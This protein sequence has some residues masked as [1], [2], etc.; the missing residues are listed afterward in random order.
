MKGN[1]AIEISRRAVLAGLFASAGQAAVAGAPLASPLP[2]ARAKGP[3]PA[4][5]PSVAEILARADLGGKISFV[6]ADAAS[7]RILESM[8]PLLGQPPASVTKAITA[9]YALDVL[10]P[11]HAFST[12]LIGT[13]TLKNGRL[14]GDLY[15]VGG[16]DPTLD[17]TALAEMA[18]ALKAAGVT[19]VAGQFFVSSGSLPHIPRIDPSQPDHLGYNP[20]V[21]GLNLNYNRV[22]FEWK[23]SGASYK[24]T[25]DA[26]TEK[27][28]PNITMARMEIVNRQAP[29]Y[30]YANGGGTE[31]WTVASSALGNSG[32]R[33]LPVRQPELYAGE[34]FHGFAR[35]M[36]IR[37]KRA[38]FSEDRINGRVLVDRKSPPLSRIM[39]GMLAYSNNLTAEVCG[40]SASIASGQTVGE[41]PQSGQAMADWMKTRLGARNPRFVD[42]SGLGENTRVSSSDMVRALVHVG[43]DSSLASILKPLVIRNQEGKV[44]LRNRA[45]MVAKTGTL[46]F[47]SGLS[48]F[49]HTDKRD[50]LVFAIFSADLPRRNSLSVAERERP[51][52]AKS[53]TKR[54]R[55][56]QWGLINRWID[57]HG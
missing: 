23:R 47:V 36:G 24:I 22:H 53:W 9:Q 33:W 41:L 15:L 21:S 35:S 31:R 54:A 43:P 3:L 28:R 4:P 38:V 17:S 6:V 11:A 45:Q 2:I 40:L 27:Y 25:M 51:V 7:G 49:I 32:S 56:M 12:R 30:T 13:G 34:V 46:N 14:S 50:A 18:A 8:N 48:G 20:A 29:V 55:A 26:R 5:V 37:L 44:D 19:D 1:A 42:H 52:G 57:L 16:G 10:G 39:Q